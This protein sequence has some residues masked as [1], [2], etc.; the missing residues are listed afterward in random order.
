MLPVRYEERFY[1]TLLADTML[2]VVIEELE[3]KKIIGAATGFLKRKPTDVFGFGY[4]D[5]HI[6]STWGAFD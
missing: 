5:N 4:G 2:A 3:T 6:T 1:E